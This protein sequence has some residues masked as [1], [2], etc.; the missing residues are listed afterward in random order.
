MPVVW[1]LG[2]GGGGWWLWRALQ[3]YLAA[4]PDPATGAWPAS[5]A[6]AAPVAVWAL[7]NTLGWLG[8]L[9]IAIAVFAERTKKRRAGKRGEPGP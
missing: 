6:M 1:A 9:A 2:V 4:T 3:N 7:L 5:R 8:S